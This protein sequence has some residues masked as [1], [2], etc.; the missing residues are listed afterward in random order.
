MIRKTI[1]ASIG[2]EFKRNKTESVLYLKSLHGTGGFPFQRSHQR[3]GISNPEPQ[4]CVVRKAA[5]ALIALETTTYLRALPAAIS[6][7]LGFPMK[8][9]AANATGAGKE[10]I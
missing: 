9:P 7:T 2:K 8:K 10:K 4:A 1:L 3:L 5:V 6:G